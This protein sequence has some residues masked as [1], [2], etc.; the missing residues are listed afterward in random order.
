MH[1]TMYVALGLSTAGCCFV[2]MV[3][4]YFRDIRSFAFK[5]VFYMSLADIFHAVGFFLPSTNTVWCEIQATITSY[6]SLSSVL[7]TAA[8]AFTLYQAV[9]NKRGDVEKFEL[10]LV[11]FAYGL[12][13]FAII[14]P[15]A[16]NTYGQAQGWC[17]IKDGGGYFT[18]GTFWRFMTFYVP[19]W[20]VI[21]YNIFVYYK[22]IRS[23]RLQLQ[24]ILEEDEDAN[25]LLRKLRLYPMILIGCYTLATINR[26]Y[27]TVCDGMV[28]FPL[29]LVSAAA[30]Y[31]CGFFNSLVYGFTD[32]VKERLREWWHENLLRKDSQ[33]TALG[34]EIL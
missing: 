10:W 4:L 6:F 20:L 25:R 2:C 17:W 16:E 27:Q 3:Y 28:W 30:M 1:I 23:L 15:L 7:W 14:P 33:T 32:T 13:I 22:V 31:L 9:I 24:L 8:I 26:I 5:L 29:T 34:Q 19:L 18:R 11:A 12:P 21:A